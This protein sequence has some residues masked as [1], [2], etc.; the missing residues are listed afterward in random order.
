[1]V[2]QLDEDIVGF[3]A[4]VA[5][6]RYEVQ[7]ER[8]ARRRLSAVV[9]AMLLG[10]VVLGWQGWENRRTLHEVQKT[11]QLIASCTTPDPD[12]T[13]GDDHVCFR[14]FTDALSG[15]STTSTTMP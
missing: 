2:A 8:E 11:N 3:T 13:D 6:L 12:P 9:V 10:S 15:R 7:N 1:M 14:A 5:M 4:E